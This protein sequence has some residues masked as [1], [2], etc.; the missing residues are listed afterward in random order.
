VRDVGR[1]VPDELERG[2]LE[3]WSTHKTFEESVKKRKGKPSFIFL[4]GP[5]TANGM[6]GVHHV[7]A[8]TTKDIVCRYKT[9]K[10]FY[11]QRKGG[12]DTHGLPVE[13]EIE[14]ELGLNSKRE[15]EEY[16]IER[17][18]R[19]CHES[20]FRY[21]KE[22]RAMTERMAFWID[23]DNPYI[24][25]K[26]DYMES[27]WWSLRQ[28]WDKGLLYKGHRVVHY[29]PRCG[30]A[31]STHEVAQGY[32][33]VREISITVKFKLKGR[34]GYIL[35]WTTT[36]WTLPGNVVLAVG[37]DI[38]Y[39]EAY[40][41]GSGQSYYVARELLSKYGDLVVMEEFK[42]KEMEGWEY[43]PLYS[44]IPLKGKK[45]YYV[46]TADF[47]STE[48]GTG[49]VHIAPMYGEDD[50][51]LGQRLDLPTF[52][53]VDTEGRF[54]PEVEKWKG[55][56]I[57]NAEAGILEDLRER[58][59]L[60]K[61]EKYTHSYHFCWRCDTPLLYYAREG[62]F[63][64]MS[65]MRE[66][67]LANN[68]KI[69]WYPE[70]LKHGRFGNFLEEVRDWA[71]TRERYWGTPF[72]VWECECGE[73][74]CI[75][76]ME[77]LKSRALN[78][79]DTSDLHRPYVDEI[80]LRCTCGGEMRRTREVIDCWYDSGAAPFAQWHYPF[81]NKEIFSA[82]FP[83]DYIS[84]GL[85][86]TRGWFYSLHAESTLLFDKPAYRHC[87]ATGLGLGADG[88]RMSKSRG[89]AVDPWD[90]FKTYGAD[91]LR[92][93]ILVTN[94]PWE[95]IL[96][97]KDVVGEA[98][99]R[100][101]NTL[102]NVY[103]FFVT[104]AMLDDYDGNEG[105]MPYEKREELDRWLLSRFNELVAEVT[106]RMEHY[107]FHQATRAIEYFVEEELSNWYVR[108]SR[109]RFW[110]QEKSEEKKSAYDT[111]FDVLTAL[112]RLLAPFTPYLAEEIFKNL[113][114]R[115]SVH[116]EDYPDSGFIDSGLNETM[117]LAMS[118]AQAGREARATAN[119]KLRQPIQAAY[120]V[121]FEPG[122][123]RFTELIGDELNT[124]TILLKK[125]ASD[126]IHYSIKPNFASFGPKFKGDSGF[127]QT[128]LSQENPD[129]VVEKMK[130]GN[131]ILEGSGK[132]FTLTPDDIAIHAEVAEG[133]AYGESRKV[134]V[135]IDTHLTPELLEEGLVRDI[136][137]RIQDMR[138]EKN[139][140]YKAEID[141]FYDGRQEV[142]EAFKNYSDYL[143]KE[144]LA[145][146]LQEG[147][148]E[149]GFQ[150]V[151]VIEGQEVYLAIQ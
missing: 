89:T 3:F 96:F 71:L 107:M 108:R 32:K 106:D 91:S 82:N 123:E 119:I 37:A 70:Y 57:K 81:E 77:E 137:R 62:W 127:V 42:G 25:L 44:V 139:L 67:L 112:A 149:E 117:T 29:C 98:Q 28:I 133:Y 49:V 131:L 144:T 20:V 60:F 92:W 46:A 128:L 5:P 45:A 95:N 73:K 35:A 83:V 22:W 97:S 84:E 136:V 103:T 39:V 61:A 142:K 135:F 18:N 14:K 134:K 31:L 65:K 27:V 19:K 30:T 116:L 110:E 102:W 99:K 122:I 2:L 118:A 105:K 47:V 115:E 145:R 138:K 43:E 48:E 78:M 140:P 109:R 4:E 58:G 68:E 55:V 36:P 23:M 13:L 79:P 87:V 64:A 16:G 129:E 56:F 80:K 17:F 113:T 24:T 15:I 126:F 104:Y 12:W 130:R 143:K 74:V 132:S 10:G 34:K 1:Y 53:T 11:V 111:M 52:H 86:Q 85:D 75:G 51:A 8:R 7:M 6:P 124:K 125:E 150:K 66:A 88:L 26:N 93:F 63:I 40:D 69:E 76:S 100:M 21:E 41:N 90:I 120:V 94:P 72:P 59:L 38:D 50:Y 54:V 33:D 141:V 9:M 147:R 151:W 148:N 146:T 114:G 101:I 121:C